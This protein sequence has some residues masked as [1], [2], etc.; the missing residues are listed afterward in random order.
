[1][2]RITREILSHCWGTHHLI[3]GGARG[4]PWRI[5]VKNHARKNAA[6]AAGGKHTE[7]LRVTGQQWRP[8]VGDTWNPFHG[9]DVD[10]HAALLITGRAGSGKTT[11][12]Q[13]IVTSALADGWDCRVVEPDRFGSFNFADPWLTAYASD[14]PDIVAVIRELVHE[15]DDRLDARAAGADSPRPVLVAID[16]LWPVGADVVGPLARLARMGRSAGIRIA[17]AA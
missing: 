8:D 12:L 5:M 7:A 11:A 9:W 10:K 2:P 4:R 14:V 13:S 3:R 15:M 6:K 16:G 17:L 1:M